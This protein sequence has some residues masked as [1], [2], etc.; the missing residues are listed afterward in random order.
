MSSSKGLS[1]AVARIHEASSTDEDENTALKKHV[2]FF[3]RNRDGVIYPRET[4]QGF[5]AIGCGV[6]LSAISAVLI[7]SA[8]SKKT[9]PRTCEL[10]WTDSMKSAQLI[11]LFT[12]GKG[13][14]MSLPIEIDN[15][16]FAKH[17]SDSG[18]Y[19]TEGRF[20]P[21]KFDEIFARHAKT[22][23]N[24]LT[25]SE[26]QEL[27]KANREPKDYRGWVAAWTEWKILYSLCKDTEGMLHKDTI[28]AVYDGSLFVKL[29]KEKASLKKKV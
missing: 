4:Y 23:P 25:A 12:Q 24:A 20:V 10:E 26:L 11:Y 21:S 5:R 27:L 18:V 22:N 13:F 28:R 1:P 19:D 15:I 3:D 2:A 7:N 9:R 6:A 17:G 29:E 8:L 16:K 14:S